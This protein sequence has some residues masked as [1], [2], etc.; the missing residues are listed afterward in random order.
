MRYFDRPDNLLPKALAWIGQSTTAIS[1]NKLIVKIAAALPAAEILA[2]THDSVTLQLPTA[3]VPDLLPRLTE[4][5]RV[6]VPYP[7]PL[8]MPCEIKMS[9][10][11]WGEMETAYATEPTGLDQ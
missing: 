6:T 2:Q 9:T 10:T 8:L 11:S 1:C 7:D 4:I 5:S 3:S